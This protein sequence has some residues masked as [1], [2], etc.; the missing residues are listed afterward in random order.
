VLIERMRAQH[1]QINKAFD[2]AE[3][4][5]SSL[6]NAEIELSRTPEGRTPN[7]DEP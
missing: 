7:G 4:M 3:S 1:A 5:M 2:F 6:A